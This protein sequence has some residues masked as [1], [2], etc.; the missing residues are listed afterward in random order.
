[1][2][3]YELKKEYEE[4]W[5]KFVRNS[6]D[7]TFFHQVGWK[8]VITKTY[9]HKPIY[10]MVL[11]KDN[12]IKGILPMFLM[13]S[14][15]FGNRLISVPFAPYGG[16]CA[17][18]AKAFNLLIN[19]AMKIAKD[20]DVKFIEFRNLNQRYIL[21]YRKFLYNNNVSVKSNYVTSILELS[22]DHE[23][24]WRYKLTK[25][26][27]K[28][29]S[30]SLRS[31]LIAEWTDD[32][33][34]FYRLYAHNMRDL[35]TPVHSKEFFKNI[36]NEFSNSSK[37]LIVR[38]NDEPIYSAFYLLYNNDVIINAWS[39][40]LRKYRKLNP[41]DFGIWF[42]I[43][44]ACVNK[45]KCYDFGRSQIGSGNFEYKRRWSTVTIPLLYVYYLAKPS[46]VPDLTSRNVNRRRFAQIWS[47]L[48]VT[49]ANIIGP[50]I[51]RHIP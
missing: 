27:R 36:L 12:E 18:D 44:Y 19:E 16:I 49:L 38:Y 17:N 10:L 5:D 31:G 1:M 8:R 45:F 7:A 30:R 13:K 22:E 50:R 37:I 2:E 28:N 33:N 3:V 39:S 23:Y 51:R 40:T 14:K 48:P 35:G 6:R 29:I 46:D 25:N 24:I 34:E 4:E 26:K 11:D 15:I 47:K 42:V 20:M 43:K 21:L 41:S 9:N 32:A